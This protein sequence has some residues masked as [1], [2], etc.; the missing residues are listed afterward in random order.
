MTRRG[1]FRLIVPATL[2]ALLAAATLALYASPAAAHI[3]L[4]R[5]RPAA[6]AV[7]TQRPARILLAF[8][9]AVDPADS[10][11][12]LLDAKWKRVRGVSSAEAVPGRDLQLQAD[13][14]QAL[15]PGR[16]EIKWKAVSL[17]GHAANG[18]I[19]FKVNTDE[20]DGAG[21]PAKPSPSASPPP[22]VSASPSAAEV[23]VGGG[24]GTLIVIVNVALLAGV[25]AAAT[26]FTRRR[27]HGK[28]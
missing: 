20:G 8:S 10:S 27:S 24:R 21:S 22:S 26:V 4:L 16:Y 7:L 18:V 1:T 17:D 2:L 19:A 3:V 5:S 9:A 23:D 28:D 11:I 14:R 15:P 13:V 12:V 25:V 6:G